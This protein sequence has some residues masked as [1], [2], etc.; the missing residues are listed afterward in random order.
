[1]VQLTEEI[2]ITK[3]FLKMVLIHVFYDHKLRGRQI[4]IKAEVFQYKE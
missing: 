2:E 3:Y 4:K 1:M